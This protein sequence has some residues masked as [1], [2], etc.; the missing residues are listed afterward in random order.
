LRNREAD[1][2]R[3]LLTQIRPFFDAIAK[4]KTAKIGMAVAAWWLLL[5][6]FGGACTWVSSS[7]HTHSRGLIL[8]TVRTLIDLVA[9]I[10]N[11]INLQIELCQESIEWAKGEQRTFLRQRIEAR[12]A[13]LY[14]QLAF[15]LLACLLVL[16][17]FA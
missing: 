14:P 17:L 16:L 1:S 3:S 8:H 2:L 11:T 5:L 4:A 7:C 12:L 15:C 9:R 6:L 10:P 13:S